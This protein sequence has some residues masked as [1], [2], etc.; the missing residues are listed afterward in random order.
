MD[1]AAII[2]TADQDRLTILGASLFANLARMTEEEALATSAFD[3]M[4]DVYADAKDFADATG[5]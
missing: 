5:H 3:L 2:A 4:K 1:I